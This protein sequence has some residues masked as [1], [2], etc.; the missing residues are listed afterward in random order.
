MSACKPE[1]VEQETRRIEET[2]TL[3]P[4]AYYQQQS[5]AQQRLYHLRAAAL[6]GAKVPGLV[7]DNAALVQAIQRIEPHLPHLDAG[8]IRFSEHAQAA[9]A[10]RSALALDHPGAALLAEHAAQVATLTA[11]VDRLQKQT[12]AV[13]EK[14]KRDVTELTEQRD[15][16]RDE[17]AA[18]TAERDEARGKLEDL[19]IKVAD[20]TEERDDERAAME[21]MAKAIDTHLPGFHPVQSPDEGI[22]RLAEQRDEAR[23]E[24]EKWKGYLKK[25]TDIAV[26]RESERDALR[27]QVKAVRE[28]LDDLDT[29]ADD[30]SSVDAKPGSEK[31]KRTASIIRET[32]R[33]VRDAL[34]VPPAETPRGIHTDRTC[35][36]CGGALET[37]RDAV[38]ETCAPE[39]QAPAIATSMAP[40]P[41]GEKG[42]P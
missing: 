27:A 37:S 22:H 23:A 4:A 28:K 26:V 25:Q 34:S 31:A 3:L 17:V 19:N 39:K 38:C 36:A 9:G 13:T 18:L 11:E 32:L 16:L 41:A 20:L 40:S 10:L 2:L 12:Q 14:Y 33:E 35:G 5:L 29:A 7:A 15:T 1:E 6:E 42:A 8:P 24:A 21:A 30:V